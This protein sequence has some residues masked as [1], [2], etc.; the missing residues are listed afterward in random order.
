MQQAAHN[1][2]L[3]TCAM[4]V[5]I[6]VTP[7]HAV[8]LVCPSVHTLRRSLWHMLCSLSAKLARRA[9]LLVMQA[10]QCGVG[11]VRQVVKLWRAD[12]SKI[13]PRAAEA[14]ADPGQY[15]NLFPDMDLA[16]Q[17]E[18]HQ[19]SHN[20]GHQSASMLLSPLARSRCWHRHMDNRCVGCMTAFHISMHPIEHNVLV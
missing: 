5:C 11:W 12:L 19:A 2:D 16:V 4:L 7:N 8:Q 1:V 18:Q 10:S 20:A 9:L 3:V 17:A 13:N 6:I 14:L 15:A